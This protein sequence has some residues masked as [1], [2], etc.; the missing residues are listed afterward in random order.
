MSG[1]HFTEHL[2]QSR[3]EI[4]LQQRGCFTKQKNRSDSK[5][6][7]VLLPLQLADLQ[8][9]SDFKDLTVRFSYMPFPTNC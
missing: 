8:N 5:Q 4:P 2:L 3:W 7:T 1:T 6:A 9:V